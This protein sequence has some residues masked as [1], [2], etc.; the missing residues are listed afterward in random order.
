MKKDKNVVREIYSYMKYTNIPSARTAQAYGCH[1]VREFADEVN[2][3]TRVY[4]ITKEQWLKIRQ[5]A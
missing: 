2:E 1:F 5:E 4:C 3:K